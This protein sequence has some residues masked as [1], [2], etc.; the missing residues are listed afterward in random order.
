M[1]I[2]TLDFDPIIQSMRDISRERNEYYLHLK[3]GQV[4]AISRELMCSLGRSREDQLEI[5]PSWDSVMIPIAREIV[6]KGSNDYVRIPEAFGQCEHRWMTEFAFN[7]FFPKLR[8]KLTLALRGRGS[9]SRFRELLKQD[10]QE[11]QRWNKFCENKWEEKIK[12]WLESHAILAVP[13]PV[14]KSKTKAA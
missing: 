10:R 5:L 2:L 13:A 8:E 9:C 6:I 1:I 14:S 7:T 4:M 11:L 3:S 12:I